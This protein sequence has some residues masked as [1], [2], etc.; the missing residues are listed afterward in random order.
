MQYTDIAIVGGGLAGSTAAVMLGRAGIGAVLIDPHPI[1]PP[2]FRC[3]K[4]VVSQIPLLH[5]TGLADAVLRVATPEQEVWIARFGDVVEKRHH[6]Q[7]NILYDTLVN[8]IRAEIPLG[9][10]FIHAK[11][12]TISATSKR[13]RITLSNGKEIS[14]RLVVLATGLNIGLRRQLGMR[15]Q[16]LSKCH[17][18]SIGFN[19]KRV[20]RSSFGFPALTYYSEQPTNRMGYLTLF[21]IDLTMRANLFVYRDLHDPLLRQ[22]RE[23]PREALFASMP[24]LRRLT[25]N[26]EVPD[27][28]KIRPIDLCLTEGYRQA[29]VVLVGDAFATSCP[30]AGT[31]VNKVF[32]DVERLCRIHIPRWLGTPGMG[33]EKISTFYE[34]GIKTACDA[35]SIAAAYYTRSLSIDPSLSWRARRVSR[36]IAQRSFGMLKRAAAGWSS[37]RGGAAAAIGG[38]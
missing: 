31:G 2:D 7:H 38:A 1:Y 36:Y 12:A 20:G 37:R 30:A 27:V 17:S 21:M 11:V 3:E 14:A 13:Q 15:H 10:E 25:G 34:D 24:G 23:A 6:H 18:I 22:L 19:V 9:T 4:L 28:F 29:G 5:R 16:V 32:T 35:H 8:T 26:I 33:E